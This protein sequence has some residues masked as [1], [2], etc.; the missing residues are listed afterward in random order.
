M[1]KKKSNRINPVIL[2]LICGCLLFAMYI[3]L[4]TLALGLWG[5]TVMGTVD[6]YDSRLDDTDAGANRSRTISKGYYFTVDGKEYRGYVMYSSDEAWPRLEESETRSELINYFSFCPYINKPSML[7]DFDQMGVGGMLYHLLA[8]PVCGFLFLLV[9]GKLGKKK[10]V[11]KKG[12]VAENINTRGNKAMFCQECGNKLPDN[13]AFCSNC[14]MKV[15]KAESDNCASCGATIPEDAVFCTNCGA[16]TNSKNVHPESVGSSDIQE[17]DNIRS[18]NL[19][20]FSDRC[21]NPEIL[22]TAKSNRKSSIGCMWIL[23][24]VPLM[25][26]PIAG[27]I[28]EDFPLGEAVVIGFSIAFIMLIVNLYGLRR[29]KQPMWEGVVTNKISKERHHHHRTSDEPDSYTTYTEYNTVIRTNMGKEKKIIERDSQRDMY[30]YLDVGDRVRYHPTFG[31]YEKYDKSKDRI[32]YCNIC[33]MM[34]PIGNG[35][36]KRCNNLLF[37]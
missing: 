34:N 2:A 33:R 12:V 32:I 13:A 24:F 10:K 28:M 1:A 25:G 29:S 20:G 5:Q 15:Q 14:G 21:N 7:T 37:K 35:R 30:D 36:C 16:A 19:V 8:P 3:S 6:S 31:T 23:V 22:A 18:S 27:L 17:R 11:A 26:F 9:I 4:S